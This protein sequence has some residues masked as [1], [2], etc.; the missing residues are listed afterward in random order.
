MKFETSKWYIVDENYCE[1]ESHR[2]T[3]RMRNIKQVFFYSPNKTNPT[4]SNLQLRAEE[5][6]L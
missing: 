3:Y 4:P 5:T 1:F 2:F 6:C